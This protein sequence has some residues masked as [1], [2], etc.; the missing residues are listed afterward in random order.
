MYHCK[1][2]RTVRLVLH[3]WFNIQAYSS[4]VETTVVRVPYG[5]ATIPYSYEYMDG[6][7][8]LPCWMVPAALVADTWHM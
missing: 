6:G 8:L 1:P 4:T 5:S 2:Y 3:L 7:G